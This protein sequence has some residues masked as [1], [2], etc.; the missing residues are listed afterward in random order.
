MSTANCSKYDQLLEQARGSAKYWV[1]KLCEALRREK[2]EMSNDDIRERVTQ[3]C[4]PIWHKCTIRDALTD[5]YK[6]KEKA[7]AGKIG[8]K[9]Q[10]AQA[11]GTLTIIEE[12]EV[13][14]KLRAENGSY[15]S[16]GQKSHTS[17]RPSLEEMN[18]QLQSQLNKS[19]QER[20]ELAIEY[21]IL[22]RENK[23]LKEKTQ[24]ELFQELHEKFYDKP[25]LLDAKQLQKISEEAGRDL[26]TIVGRY[27]TII[28]GAVESGEPVPIGTYVITKPDKKLVPV[29]IF[30]DFGKKKIEVSL[31]EKKLAG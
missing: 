3:D 6:Q 24:P 31:W 2:S 23:I 29:R 8:R 11:G 18:A 5:E 19:N 13:P 1:P 10:L 15:S 12:P 27:N 4:L 21:E 14:V 17:G 16:T 9:K 25:G 22:T 28:Q 7:Q 30:V 20:D 26:E